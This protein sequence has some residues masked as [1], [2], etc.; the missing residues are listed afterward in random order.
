[1]K[2]YYVTVLALTGDHKYIMQNEVVSADSFRIEDG[3]YKF[4][5]GS[6]LYQTFPTHC[7]IVK[8]SE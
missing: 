3:I 6:R 5:S 1:M 8:I 2:K 7:T 4:Y